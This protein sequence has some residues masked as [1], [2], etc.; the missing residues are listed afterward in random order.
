MNQRGRERGGGMREGEGSKRGRGGGERKE[1][2]REPRSNLAK[3]YN[4]KHNESN[5]L[6]CLL[7]AGNPVID[8]WDRFM[9]V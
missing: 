2:K 6:T 1:R 5:Q 8:K 4:K 9:K 7:R 3:F